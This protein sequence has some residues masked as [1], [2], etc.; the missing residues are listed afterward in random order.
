[1]LKLFI[2]GGKRLSG[3]VVY[4][5]KFRMNIHGQSSVFSLNHIP[6]HTLNRGVK[7]YQLYYN[8]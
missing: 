4:T 2:S 6:L 8:A 5:F 1:M 7:G 3:L